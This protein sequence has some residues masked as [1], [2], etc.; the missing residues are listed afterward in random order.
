MKTALQLVCIILLLSGCSQEK[1]LLREAANAVER[2]NYEKAIANYDE[3]LK[4]TATLFLA[5]RV[6]A[7]SSLNS[8]EDMSKRSPI[9]K[10]P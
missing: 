1:K 7:W 2:S 4:K 8:W 3:I 6:K 9:L 10:R 5:M